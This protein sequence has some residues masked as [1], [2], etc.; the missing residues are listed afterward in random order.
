MKRAQENNGVVIYRN[1]DLDK[2]RCKQEYQNSALEDLRMSGLSWSEGPLLGGP[3]GPYNQSERFHIYLNYWQRLRQTGHIYPCD[4]SRKDVQNALSAPHSHEEQV[5][6]P[7]LRPKPG[8]GKYPNEPGSTNWR[9]KVPDGETISF[10]DKRCGSCAFIAGKD[11]G[12]FLIWRKDG[13]PSYELAVVVDDHEMDITE[14]VRGEDLLLST[15]RQLLI[16]QALNLQIPNFYHCE[17]I[18]DEQ[19]KRLAKRNKS[20]SLR[21]IHGSNQW[22]SIK[23]LHNL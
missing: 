15:A 12:D 3:Y 13:M 7:E 20:L 2:A 18:K 1:E 21:E 23:K 11:F 5:F 16:Y 22:N 8:T 9:F 4:K 17:L 10:T 6:P 19:G 14:I